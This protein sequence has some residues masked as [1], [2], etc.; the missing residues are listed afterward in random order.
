MGFL[1]AAILSQ[2]PCCPPLKR[3]PGLDFSDPL[4]FEVESDLGDGRQIKSINWLTVINEEIV[5]KLGGQGA[6]A[7]E[8]GESC[9]IH[10]IDGGLIIQAGSEP[11]LGDVNRGLVLDDYR[12][13]AKVLEPVRFN[14]YR[15]GL[16]VLPEP[17]DKIEETRRWLRRFE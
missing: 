17:Y 6:L 10:G 16:F 14:D 12:R 4:H 15:R 1:P 2:R 13:V 3:F 11:Q 5:G 9:P 8:L 7:K